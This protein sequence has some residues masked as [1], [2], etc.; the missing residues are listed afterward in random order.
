MLR[1][2]LLF[3]L[4]TSSISNFAQ[5]FRF[6]DPTFMF[7]SLEDYE[8]RYF[9]MD[10]GVLKKNEV[11]S[12]EI[13]RYVKGEP[14]VTKRY[15]DKEGRIIREERK[16]KKG[17]ASLVCTYDDRGN[18]TE[19]SGINTKGQEFKTSYTFNSQNKITA[20]QRVDYKGEYAAGEME[21]DSSGK[22]LWHK[23]YEK[24][25]EVPVRELVY[26]YYENGDRKTTSYFEKGKLKHSWN[27][28]CKPEGELIGVKTKDETT[29]C[30][31][32]EIDS[33]GNRV[34]WERKFNEKGE[35]T[36]VKMVHSSDSLVLSKQIYSGADKLVSE[37]TYAY[38]D[39]GKSTG[40]KVLAFDKH[41][42]SYLSSD[43][44]IDEFG[45]RKTKAYNKKGEIT[46]TDLR[47]KNGS[48]KT[49]KL[50]HSQGRGF[51]TN[52]Y[53]YN[54]ESMIQSEVRMQRKRTYVTEY[55]Y[56]FY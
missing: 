25:R 55:N 9:N 23:I 33:S 8:L 18:L 54:E 17:L 22:L 2:L 53:N 49:I 20:W 19:R 27:Y 21:F 47:V 52:L 3:C 5:N 46:Y 14:S 48:G 6:S 50:Q 40:Y 34:T 42:K 26:S 30:K 56:T 44:T 7:T 12:C 29:I 51:Y 16:T 31:T 38:S 39:E 24:N 28:D 10:S 36:K 4:I 32:E 15:F 35:L 11:K 41:G 37:T 43:T 13:I 45:T 1:N